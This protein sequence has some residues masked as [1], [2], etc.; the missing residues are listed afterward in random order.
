MYPIHV[1]LVS[2]ISGLFALRS[3]DTGH[4]ETSTPNDPKMT[5]NPTRS[6][7]PHIC[8]VL[9]VCLISKMLVNLMY[10]FR[11]DV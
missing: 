11:G 9:L 2:Q 5:V 3:R 4:F 8:V 10:T 6:N 7:A 1:L